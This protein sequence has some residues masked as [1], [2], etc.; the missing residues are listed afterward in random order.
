M[1]AIPAPIGKLPKLCPRSF[2]PAASAHL[3]RPIAFPHGVFDLLHVGHADRLAAARS[4]GRSLVVGVNGDESARRL[5]K[6]PGRPLNT[7]LDR[8]SVVA[9]LEAVSLVVIFEEPSPLTLL[10]EL[11]PDV[12][13]KGGDYRTEQ[14]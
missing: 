13:V 8:A 5:A 14:L 11:R 3:P 10:E 9:A 4:E 7:A 12:Y 6:G 2:L 1:N